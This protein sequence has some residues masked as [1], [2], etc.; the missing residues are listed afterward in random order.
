VLLALALVTLAG[1]ATEG[2]RGALA[3][4]LAA[5]IAMG[6]AAVLISG[7]LTALG[8]GGLVHALTGS[9]LWGAV[10]TA[11]AAQFASQ[12]AFA[13]GSLSWSLPVLTVAD[14]LAAVPAA[15]ILLGERLE[16]GHA[17]VW[18]PAGIVAAVGVVLLARS[19]R[20][21]TVAGTRVA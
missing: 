11:V 8:S 18:L 5:G 17:A 12:Q 2:P 10:V 1:R 21:T 15:R 3:A 19:R 4:G 9:A 20:S 16:P 7:A 6:I 13:R 14:P